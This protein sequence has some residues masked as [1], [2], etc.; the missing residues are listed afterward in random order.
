MFSG[1]ARKTT[2]MRIGTS[3]ELTSRIAENQPLQGPPGQDDLHIELL[4]SHFWID[5]AY[6]R[7]GLYICRCFRTDPHICGL[8]VVDFQQ[9]WM[10]ALR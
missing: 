4:Q 6:K 3:A 5:S 7:T 9:F 10:S 2:N 1:F 8:V